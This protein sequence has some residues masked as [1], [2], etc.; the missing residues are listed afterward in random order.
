M[1]ERLAELLGLDVGCVNVKAKTG[2]SVGHIGRKEAIASQAV[3][4]IDR[5]G[6]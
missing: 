3:V 6:P 5:G 4:L 2:E 1:R